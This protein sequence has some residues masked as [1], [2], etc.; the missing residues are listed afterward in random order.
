MKESGMKRPFILSAAIAMAMSGATLLAQS[1]PKHEGP[2]QPPPP[3]PGQPGEA[4]P[5]GGPEMNR[6]LPPGMGRDFGGDG[7]TLGGKFETPVTMRMF[8]RITGDMTLSEEQTEQVRMLQAEYDESMKDWNTA[9]GQEYREAMRTLRAGGA[10]PAGMGGRQRGQ[11]QPGTGAGPQPAGPGGQPEMAEPARPVRPEGVRPA[12]REGL[13]VRPPRGEGDPNQPPPP[14][15]SKEEIEAA[16]AKFK[17]LNETRPKA[18]PYIVGM[19]ETLTPEQQT[20]FTAKMKEQAQRMREQ[21]ER[22]REMGP[23]GQGMDPANMSPEDRER[24]ERMR[25]RRGQRE[26]GPAPEQAKPDDIQFEE[27]EKDGGG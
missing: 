5:L 25:Q 6:P 15:P 3:P 1:N 11:R 27:D 16:Q 7:T 24:M 26:G 4:G 20:E 10:L 18:E 2:S 17:A 8:V 22:W 13:R 19:W 21:M 12:D 23:P 9:H 14:P